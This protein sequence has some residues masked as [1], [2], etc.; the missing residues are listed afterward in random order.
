[1]LADKAFKWSF[2]S[3]ADCKL[4]T[5]QP[6]LVVKDRALFHGCHMC[7]VII[8]QQNEPLNPLK[9]YLH[10]TDCVLYSCLFR[11]GK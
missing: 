2:C 11:C 10:V 9:P 6:V 3:S 8:I 4:S 1:M 5:T 7:N